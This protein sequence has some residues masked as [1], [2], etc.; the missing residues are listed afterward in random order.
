MHI[1]VSGCLLLQQMKHML[2]H[3]AEFCQPIESSRRNISSTH[4]DT[5]LYQAEWRIRMLPG[6]VPRCQGVMMVLPWLSELLLWPIMAVL[7]LIHGLVFGRP[8]V[9]VLGGD[10]HFAGNR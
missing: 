8:A 7:S 10:Y 5:A 6:Q 2:Q 9:G 1:F 4:N 3:P